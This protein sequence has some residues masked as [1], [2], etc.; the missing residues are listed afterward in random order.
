MYKTEHVAYV[1]VEHEQLKYAMN[2][3]AIAVI[4]FKAELQDT[5]DETYQKLKKAIDRESKRHGSLLVPGAPVM[6]FVSQDESQP[7]GVFGCY[8]K[9]TVSVKEG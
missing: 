7:V 2:G 8:I 9:M 4:T 3:G 1:A 5:V 6:E